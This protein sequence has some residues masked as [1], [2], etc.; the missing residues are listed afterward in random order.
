MII[1]GVS[2]AS[3]TTSHVSTFNISPRTNGK[4]MTLTALV[5]PKITVDLP[6]VAVDVSQWTHLEQVELADPTFYVPNKIDLL[7]GAEY[8]LDIML[9]GKIQGPKGTPS[10]HNSI[11]ELIVCGKLS[12]LHN[13]LSMFKSVT[14][15]TTTVESLVNRFWE[16]EEVP[17]LTCMSE[18]DQQCEKHFV[19]TFTRDSSGRYT[20]RLPFVKE[21]S[22]V[23]NSYQ[24]AVQRLKKVER[25]L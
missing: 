12:K 8:S 24:L 1:D 15:C 2:N 7:I 25:S 5:S 19:E 9:D 22:L 21:S 4:Q 13:E 3:T 23:N 14:C 17:R 18:E 6:T 11:F 10:L 16:L 20:G